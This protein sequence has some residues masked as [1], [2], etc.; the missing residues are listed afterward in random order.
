M[1]TL[2]GF[3]G[4]KNPFMTKASLNT[5]ATSKERRRRW[6]EVFLMVL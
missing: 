4:G 2:A 6:E 1:D 5:H 3:V